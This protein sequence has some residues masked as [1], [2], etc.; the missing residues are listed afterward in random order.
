MYGEAQ[1]RTI[2]A[3]PPILARVRASPP[4]A[5]TTELLLEYGVLGTA[6]TLHYTLS[7]A[8]AAA[9]G[10]GKVT[11]VRIDVRNDLASGYNRLYVYP[12]QVSCIY[13]T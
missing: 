10:G 5:T 6:G 4:D 8:E 11:C 12:Q 1:A 7:E 13:T 3:V 2:E 9:K